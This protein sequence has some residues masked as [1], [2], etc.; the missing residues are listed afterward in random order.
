M[1]EHFHAKLG[2]RSFIGFW[3]IV[4]KHRQTNGQTPVKTLLPRLPSAWVTIVTSTTAFAIAVRSATTYAF[5][6]FLDVSLAVSYR[7]IANCI[8]KPRAQWIIGVIATRVRVGWNMDVCPGRHEVSRRRWRYAVAASLSILISCRTCHRF[9]MR[10]L[11]CVASSALFFSSQFF[12]RGTTN[13]H[14]LCIRVWFAN[15]WIFHFFPIGIR[16]R[17]PFSINVVT[18]WAYQRTMFGTYRHSAAILYSAS[19]V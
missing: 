8:Y 3:D 7:V 11:S 9:P 17:R 15:N 19:A 1:V 12:W 4:R 14:W 5:C 2:C 16:R 13:F 10:C 6:S 18:R